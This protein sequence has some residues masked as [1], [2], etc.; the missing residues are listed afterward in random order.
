MYTF[1]YTYTWNRDCYILYNKT[2]EPQTTRILCFSS[3]IVIDCF[4]YLQKEIV[5]IDG[6]PSKGY[7]TMLSI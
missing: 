1:L 2:T 7:L 4:E 5:L 3:S 6:K